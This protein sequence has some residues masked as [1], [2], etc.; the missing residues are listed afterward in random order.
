[1]IQWEKVTINGNG[2]LIC[3]EC[4]KLAEQVIGVFGNPCYAHI[5]K[6]RQVSLTAQSR[7]IEELGI[8]LERNFLN[9]GMRPRGEEWYTA[10]I[11]YVLVIQIYNQA[12][13]GQWEYEINTEPQTFGSRFSTKEDAFE[14]AI[15][16]A[17][18]LLNQALREL[19]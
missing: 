15:K 14:A 12:K 10:R 19:E 16:I 6:L 1:M 2:E 4:K 13:S 8:K 17:K 7:L 11:G 3:P 9:M 5:P 18:H